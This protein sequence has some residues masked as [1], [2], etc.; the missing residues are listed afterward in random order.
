LELHIGNSGPQLEAVTVLTAIWKL[1]DQL[2]IFSLLQ[3]LLTLSLLPL[4]TASA[5]SAATASKF[6]PIWALV[7]AVGKRARHTTLCCF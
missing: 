1:Q 3:L 4:P 7:L 2:A 6:K 5:T